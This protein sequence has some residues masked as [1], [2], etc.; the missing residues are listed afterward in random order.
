MVLRRQDNPRVRSGA[1]TSYTDSAEVGGD[2]VHAG[3]SA[4]ACVASAGA[5]MQHKLTLRRLGRPVDSAL[6][7]RTPCLTKPV[8]QPGRA[9]LESTPGTAR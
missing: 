1:A 9:R 7:P 5:E 2:G 6:Y 3:A 4:S 8:R